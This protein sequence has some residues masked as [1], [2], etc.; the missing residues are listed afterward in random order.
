MGTGPDIVG[1]CM[2]EA[3]GMPMLGAMGG[4]R[5]MG[6]LRLDRWVSNRYAEYRY[7]V[8]LTDGPGERELG[9]G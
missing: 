6:P 4:L 8:A 9:T 2:Y 5:M 7:R 1:G 3:G